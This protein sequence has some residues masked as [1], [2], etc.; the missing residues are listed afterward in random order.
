METPAKHPGSTATTGFNPFPVEPSPELEFPVRDKEN[1]KLEA[2]DLFSL[3]T[4]DIIKQNVPF[5]R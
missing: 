2:V 5:T 1:V 3:F 4:A